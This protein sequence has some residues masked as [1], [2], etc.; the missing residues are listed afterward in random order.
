MPISCNQRGDNRDLKKQFSF[1]CHH[2]NTVHNNGGS[3]LSSTQTKD[4]LCFLNKVLHIPVRVFV[5]AGAPGPSLGY[6]NFCP[7]YFNFFLTIFFLTIPKFTCFRVTN[8]SIMTVKTS[9]QI[10]QKWPKMHPLDL[11]I[12]KRDLALHTSDSI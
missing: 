1:G 8:A 7:G 12:S 6:F 10:D 9:S 3:P 2:Y 11:K 4:I 5:R